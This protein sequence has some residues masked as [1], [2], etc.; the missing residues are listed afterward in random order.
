MINKSVVQLSNRSY[1]FRKKL[2]QIKKAKM[3]KIVE[4]VTGHI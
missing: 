4:N 1:K 2:H 3:Y